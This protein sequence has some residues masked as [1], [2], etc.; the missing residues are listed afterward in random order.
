MMN[1]REKLMYSIISNISGT[2]APIVFKGALITKLILQ[3]NGF[4]QIERA[5]KDIDANWI[6]SPPTMDILVETINQSLGELFS[7]FIPSLS[8]HHN[9]IST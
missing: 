1:E 6:G 5:T 7:Y 3:E 2:D 4:E 9:V 8:N